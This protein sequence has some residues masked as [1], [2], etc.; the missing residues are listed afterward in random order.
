VLGLP[1]IGLNL[2]RASPARRDHKRRAV[3]FYLARGRAA[4]AAADD[5]VRRDG[6]P[7]RAPRRAGQLFPDSAVSNH[8]LQVT[9]LSRAVGGGAGV[10]TRTIALSTVFAALAFV[11]GVSV[12][13]DFGLRSW[14]ETAAGI[15]SRCTCRR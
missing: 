3:A 6:L 10:S 14:I 7:R 12:A 9:T 2:A 1:F 13:A 4:A 5:P 8:Q 15:C 11:F